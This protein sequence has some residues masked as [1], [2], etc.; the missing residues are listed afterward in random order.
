MCAFEAPVS[1]VRNE[2]LKNCTGVHRGICS[3]P[4]V[5]LSF[6]VSSLPEAL[7]CPFWEPLPKLDVRITPPHLAALLGVD[8]GAC[9]DNFSALMAPFFFFFGGG[10]FAESLY[11][12]SHYAFQAFQYSLMHYD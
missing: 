11:K 3:R 2:I 4:L 7:V 8:L 10:E 6:S 1:E 12:N 5:I 9:Q